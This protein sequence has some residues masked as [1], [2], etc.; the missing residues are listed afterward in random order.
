MSIN[1]T[2]PTEC[3]GQSC[4][5]CPECE[6]T[7]HTTADGM[8]VEEGSYYHEI[9]LARRERVDRVTRWWAKQ[10]P[11]QLYFA[12]CFQLRFGGDLFPDRVAYR[13]DKHR[14][15]WMR[16]DDRLTW[17]DGR[18]TILQDVSSF[19]GLL[20]DDQTAAKW[21]NLRTFNDVLGLSEG[22]MA[23]S[24]DVEKDLLG[25]PGGQVYDL[26]GGYAFPNLNRLPV[27]RTTGASPDNYICPIG[28]PCVCLWHKFLDWATQGDVE[29]E[30]SLQLN[31]GASVFAGNPSHRLN[32]LVGGGSNGK[33][34]FLNAISAALG[35]YAGTAPALAFTERGDHPT[36][37]AGIAKTRFC[38]AAEVRGMWR[39][40]S[41][42]AW[43]GGDKVS[44]RFMRQDYF[45]VEP[46]CTFWIMTNNP[47]TPKMVDEAMKR[48]I[49]IW[50]FGNKVKEEDK[51][52]D[53]ET[54][55]TSADMLPVILAWIL[56]GAARYVGLR[57]AP[58]PDCAKV[59]LDTAEYFDA[60][61]SVQTWLDER[62]EPSH[63]QDTDT[64]ASAAFKD[65][66][67]WCQAEGWR[68]LTR[69][70]WGTTMGRRIRKR[71]GRKG[72]LYNLTLTAP[73]PDPTQSNF[74]LPG[75]NH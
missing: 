6:I 64:S 20:V 14:G 32:V 21:L 12:E 71:H 1:V 2:T 39:E 46:E 11:N 40:G 43:T 59:K 37:L 19:V 75:A 26:T 45:Q 56:E 73:S 36:A 15:R 69:Q 3:A 48:R 7:W 8:R 34:V 4:A 51:D 28:N 55:L 38:T 49:R 62:T 29:M 50:V 25:L 27:F 44:I 41:I 23:I 24:Q 53:L 22:P 65:F 52:L 74:D 17:V 35:D 31:I 68:P 72:V 57:G 42:L 67:D 33:T 47:P 54:K 5:G 63:M 13:Y 70:E 9:D 66:V 60:S 58:I 18:N 30:A 61:D 16:W 10:K